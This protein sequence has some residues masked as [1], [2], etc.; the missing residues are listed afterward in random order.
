MLNCLD[1]DIPLEAT[2]TPEHPL[3]ERCLRRMVAAAIAEGRRET[4]RL[5]AQGLPEEAIMRIWEKRSGTKWDEATQS[6][7]PHPKP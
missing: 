2:R 1:C 4:Q 5:K 6:H 3:C 7:I